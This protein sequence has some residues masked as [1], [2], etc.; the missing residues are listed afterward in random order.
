[1]IGLQPLEAFRS[2]SDVRRVRALLAVLGRRALFLVESLALAILTLLVTTFFV[3]RA[4]WSGTTWEWGRFWTHYAAAPPTARRPIDIG[5]V[6]T[7]A[8]LCAVI[9]WIRLPAARAFWD[10]QERGGA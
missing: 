1:M 6:L 8:G 10:A 5:L 7:L 2:R 4:D 9:G 3:V